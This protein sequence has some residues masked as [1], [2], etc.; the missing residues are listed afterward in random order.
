MSGIG[1]ALTPT[2]T[3]S[4]AEH[5]LNIRTSCNPVHHAAHCPGRL[6]HPD[7]L[8]RRL[9]L[10]LLAPVLVVVGC[11]DAPKSPA[12]KTEVPDP[13]RKTTP[14]PKPVATRPAVPE[15]DA[16]VLKATAELAAFKTDVR[17]E[18]LAELKRRER[19]QAAEAESLGA[20][21][22]FER[23]QALEALRFVKEHG[24]DKAPPDV[25]K[26]ARRGSQRYVA[27][28]L[29]EAGHVV[30][31]EP[32]RYAI[33][34]RKTL[35]AEFASATGIAEEWSLIRPFDS[36]TS[37]EMDE[38]IAAARDAKRGGLSGINRRG[39]SL[40]IRGGATKFVGDLLDK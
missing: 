32:D 22:K 21:N 30:T 15:V 13:P 39:A 37:A 28:S 26:W 9:F 40:L 27:A 19:V 20:M 2:M 4:S 6:S 31:P 25:L 38:A 11:G 35:Y 18:L 14:K 17:S 16:A 33:D 5:L 29:R 7:M 34:T 36:L 3:A 24:A 10:A 23:E 8:M 1:L 12:P